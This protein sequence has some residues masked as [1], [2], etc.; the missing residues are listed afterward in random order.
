MSESNQVRIDITSTFS[1]KGVEE[2][3]RAQEGLRKSTEI[4]AAQTRQMASAADAQKLSIR[5]AADEVEKLDDELTGFLTTADKAFRAQRMLDQGADLL[6]RSLGAGLL[7]QKQHDDMLGKL[8]AKYGPIASGTEKASQAAT[9]FT[10]EQR[11]VNESLR[12]MT[13]NLA[14]GNEGEATGNL[15]TLA[16]RMYGIA[17][18][19][20]AAAAG[21]GVTAAA[22]ALLVAHAERGDRALNSVQTLLIARGGTTD[23]SELGALMEQVRS[24]PGMSREAA[25]QT[26]A[27]L[28]SVPA[29]AG[30]MFRDLSLL[31]ADFAAATGKQAPQAAQELAKAFEGPT[32]GAAALDRQLNFLT[33][34]QLLQIQSL[35]RQGRVMEAQ[36]VLY[37][38]LQERTAGLAQKGMT[39]L[40]KATD[41]VEKAWERLKKS[42]SDSAPIRTARSALAELLTIASALPNATDG[43]VRLLKDLGL[44]RDP[45]LG[46]LPLAT[47]PVPK[48]PSFD[49]R[50]AAQNADLDARIKRALGA[51][52]GHQGA[53]GQARELRDKAGLLREGMNAAMVRGDTEA[54]KE[55]Q[56]AL[57]AVNEELARM[58]RD[59]KIAEMHN[60]IAELKGPVSEVDKVTR[61]LA[62]SREKLTKAQIDA[63][64][65][66]A[67]EIDGLVQL[68]KE[69]KAY[70]AVVEQRE[71]AEKEYAEYRA[72]LDKSFLGA[73]AGNRQSLARGELGLIADPVARAK[74]QAALERNERDE[75]IRAIGYDPKQRDELLR[76]SNDLYVQR[77]AQLAEDLKPQWRKMLEGWQDNNRLMRDSY[78]SFVGSV[79]SAGEQI[80]IQF[81]RTGRISGTAMLQAFQDEISKSVYRKYFA[82][83]VAA[84]GDFAAE[85]II[86][87]FSGNSFGGADVGGVG[88]AP[89]HTGRGPG[90]FGSPRTVHPAYFERAPRFHSGIGPGE[91]PAI[92]RQDESVLTPGQMRALGQRTPNVTIQLINQSSVPV[93][94]TQSGPPQFDGE[95]FVVGVV[96]RDMSRGGPIR[97]A[98]K[99]AT[100]PVD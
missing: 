92:I 58:G 64:L 28:A 62:Q 98:V 37:D 40:E 93:E 74:A 15:A 89:F 81:G 4:T 19:A 14:R 33:G 73:H 44:S 2:A 75:A 38:A 91:L 71:A 90:E 39:E 42:W 57:G 76:Q 31:V 17:P 72:G 95:G 78:D 100:G 24:L 97:E 56:R 50:M 26:L 35:E 86:G 27:A 8:A 79:V 59:P 51:G 68:Q 82:P 1:G 67:K 99:R 21:I 94:A 88:A 77:M 70:I 45:T 46:D 30:P 87:A 3:R 43:Y 18:A 16:T 83:S 23:R 60:R 96:L 69:T 63:R 9:K 29:L 34:S 10:G 36:K 5:G 32:A 80:A 41:G 12:V 61:D 11:K 55:L 66:A 7:T 6:N 22:V 54:F 20:V 65:A 25:Q 49:Q 85:R 84:F 52:A 53:F 48:G 47:D 13:L